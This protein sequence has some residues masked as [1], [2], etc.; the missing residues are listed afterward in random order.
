[1]FFHLFVRVLLE[2]L[3]HNVQSRHIVVRP[4]S[5]LDGDVCEHLR[6]G[7][8]ELCEGEV[9]LVGNRLH[10]IVCEN[11]QQGAVVVLD[12]LLGIHHY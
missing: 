5:V 12:P 3:Q 2:V 9:V 11:C 6:E 7:L 10:V 4:V 8:Q 1:M